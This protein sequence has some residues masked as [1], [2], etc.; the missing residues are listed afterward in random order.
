M[1]KVMSFAKRGTVG[2]AAVGVVCVFLLWL[3]FE[4]LFLVGPR[5]FD[6][7]LMVGKPVPFVVS[8]LGETWVFTM[9]PTGK[10]RKELQYKIMAPGMEVVFSGQDSSKKSVRRFEYTPAVTGKHILLVN[11]TDDGNYTKLGWLMINRDDK[12]V[13]LR[14][15]SHLWPIKLGVWSPFYPRDQIPGWEME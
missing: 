13:I 10:K 1:G 9:G 4:A 14:K 6:G 7:Q 5:V 11:Y 15:F 3:G 8:E 2:M 12:A